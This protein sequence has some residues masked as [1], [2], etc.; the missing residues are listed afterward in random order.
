VCLSILIWVYMM[1]IMILYVLSYMFSHRVF[2]MSFSVVTLLCVLLWGCGAPS[3]VNQDSELHGGI[4]DENLGVYL[5]DKTQISDDKALSYYPLFICSEVSEN[6][7]DWSSCEEWL[8]VPVK[9]VGHSQAAK[10]ERDQLVWAMVGLEFQSDSLSSTDTSD[11]ASGV[12]S[13]VENTENSFLKM[14]AAKRRL[15]DMVAKGGRRVVE[16]AVVLGLQKG[17][18]EYINRTDINSLQDAYVGPSVSKRSLRG[19]KTIADLQRINRAPKLWQKRL[20]GMFSF[21]KKIG[22]RDSVYDISRSKLIAYLGAGLVAYGVG[23]LIYGRIQLDQMQNKMVFKSEDVSIPL[24]TDILL[25][26]KDGDKNKVVEVKNLLSILESIDEAM[27]FVTF[28]D[29]QSE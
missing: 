5:G 8:R 4:K 17:A 13:G 3:V 2:L 15:E 21:T 24:A 9:Y 25:A 6:I 19:T 14:F 22:F 27:F 26:D 7:A 28:L 1:N 11:P 23:R 20:N 18:Y 29:S 12:E 10:Q 16:G